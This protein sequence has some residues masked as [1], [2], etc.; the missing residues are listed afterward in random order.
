MIKKPKFWDN[1]NFNFLSVLLFP[2]TIPIRINNLLINFASKSK[3]R[4]FFLFVLAIYT[5]GE[6]EKLHLL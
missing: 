2:F 6:L 5:L 4:K 1:D 3:K